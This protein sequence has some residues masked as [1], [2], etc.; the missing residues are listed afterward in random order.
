MSKK[1]KC[2]KCHLEYDKKVYECPYCHKTRFNPTGLIS[3]TILIII[4][5]GALLFFKGSDIL[6]AI[7][8]SK[9]KTKFER[10]GIVY[11]I[12]TTSYDESLFFNEIYISHIVTI[13]NTTN[14]DVNNSIK[15]TIYQDD[16]L[17]ES[18]TK[19]INLQPDKFTEKTISYNPK[20]VW[21]KTEIYGVFNGTSEL[22]FVLY[23]PTE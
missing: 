17:I 14:Q 1:I 10:N 15:F 19:T 8:H 2:K 5:L 23:N 3:V 18:D 20:E 11:E 6:S 22:M 7:Q 12:K 21:N 9:N 13:H 4:A 16:Y